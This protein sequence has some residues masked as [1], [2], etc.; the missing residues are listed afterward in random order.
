MNYFSLYIYF[1]NNTS[2]V[3]CKGNENAEEEF[4]P[5]RKHPYHQ[6]MVKKRSYGIISVNKDQEK[7]SQDC[8]QQLT[9]K[10]QEVV[11]LNAQLK[12][13]VQTCPSSSV[14]Q[15]SG[16]SD[17]IEPGG[18]QKVFTNNIKGA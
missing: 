4:L 11:K 8:K 7:Q 14:A 12:K 6:N 5:D 10:N 3:I 13:M 17:L 18:I 16:G 15:S 1:S 9:D 2:V